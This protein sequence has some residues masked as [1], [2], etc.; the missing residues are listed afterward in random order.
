MRRSHSVS[1]TSVGLFAFLDV[2]MSTMGSLILVLMVVSPKIR[3]EK[4]AKAATEVARDVVKVEPAPAPKPVLT[5]APTPVVPKRETIDLNAKFATRVAELSGQA[6]DKRRAAVDAQRAASAERERYQ[7][8]HKN[9]EQLERELAELRAAKDRTLASVQDLSAEGVKVESELA[10][11]G[12][13]LRK[14][15]D[16]IAHESTEYSFAAYDGVSGTT[17]RP[18]VIECADSQIKFLQEDIALTSADITGFT[19]AAN[20]LLAGAEALLEYWSTHSAPNDPK[21]YV[22]IVVR[23]SGTLSYY[24]ARNLLER[25]KAPFGYEL[26]AEDQKLAAPPPDAQAVVACREAIAKA[27]AKR[28]SVFGDVFATGG[29]L[30]SRRPSRAG[31]GGS[32]DDL[33]EGAGNGAG[34]NGTGG[35]GTGSIGTGSNGTGGKPA[36]PFDDPFGV[37]ATGSTGT[38][39]GSGGDSLLASGNTTTGGPGSGSVGSGGVGSGGAGPASLGF[40]GGGLTN[41]GPASGGSDTGGSTGGNAAGAGL[42]GVGPA[43]SGSGGVG[44]QGA[45]PAGGNAGGG[46][47]NDP[48]KDGSGNS[49]NEPD[50]NGAGG[51]KPGG[52]LVASPAGG[53]LAGGNAG[54]GANGQSGVSGSESGVE[55][56]PPPGAGTGSDPGSLA[57]SATSAGAGELGF[58][59]E[60]AGFPQSGQPQP[61]DGQAGQATAQASSDLGSFPSTPIVQAST[62]LSRPASGQQEIGGGSGQSD[63]SAAAGGSPGSPPMA[64]ESGGASAQGES[65]LPGGSPSGASSGSD[66]GGEPGQSSGGSAD[67]SE[68]AGLTSS[69]HDSYDAPPR[70]GATRRWGY[71]SPQASI[72]FEHDVTIWIGA[73]AIVVGGQP[74]IPINRAESPRRLAALVVPALDRE[75][76][77]WGRPPD[78]LY[79]VP[80]VKFVVSPGGNLPYERLRPAI[81]RHGL[82]SSVDYQLELES[83][84]QTF[85]SWVQ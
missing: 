53:M 70:S 50:R 13:R 20:P 68:V 2:L 72:G 15:R 22:L 29:S 26:L 66:S 48:S 21:P 61:G 58:T 44:S 33:P 45:G 41:G 39:K 54:T 56:L 30:N 3:Q 71:S 25:M 73:R 69:S 7:Q 42:G 31:A 40:G 8:I 64:S 6:D 82:V 32:R 80:N 46:Q 60:G 79:W 67:G 12:S 37:A 4:I 63:P 17:R 81:E 24:R 49:P 18:I 85:K 52:S 38:A 23:P 83:P 27:I 74:P 14:I 76:R 9:R 65:S 62:G 43:G 51:F 11:R 5:P 28:E 16:H 10:K 55:L 35:N 78:H 19:S 77:T 34:S 75:A 1:E 57:G 36:S 59:A 47:S 84:R